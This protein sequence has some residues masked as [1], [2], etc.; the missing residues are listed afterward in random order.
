MGLTQPHRGGLSDAGRVIS[1]GTGL[2]LIGAGLVHVSAAADHA[3]IALLAVGFLISAYLQVALGG[4]LIARRPG[5][6]LIGA[7]VAMTVACVGLWLLSRTVGLQFLGGEP[8]EPIGFKDAVCVLFEVCSLPG[9]L[10]LASSDLDRLRLPSAALGRQSLRA[11]AAGV[12]ALLLP[13]VLFGGHHHSHGALAAHAHGATA[14]AHGARH[15]A[16]HGQLA[17]AGGH[18]G[19][20]GHGAVHSA[21]L[22]L[23]AGHQHPA[24]ASHA[25]HLSAVHA[26]HTGHLSPGAHL[27]HSG[28]SGHVHQLALGGGGQPVHVHQHAGGGGRHPAGHT[29]TKGGSGGGHQHG[30][31]HAGGG[32]GHSGHPP[33]D[34]T[35]AGHHHE[36]EPQ[37][38][39]IEQLEGQVTQLLPPGR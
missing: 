3:D 39:P 13:S 25:G 19:H 22:H 32:Q 4:L 36:P 17:L 18:G 1:C 37:P 20:A 6:L 35:G 30:Q 21:R 27:G 15:S 7:G 5:R 26:G 24:G 38:G 28:H 23:A 34:A 29:H 2:L 31:Q 14:A 16:G 8:K 9:L 33:G 10:L 11:L 12:T